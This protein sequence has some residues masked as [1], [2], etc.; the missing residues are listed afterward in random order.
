MIFKTSSNFKFLGWNL[1]SIN[2]IKTEGGYW[3]WEV[4]K[5]TVSY[6]SDVIPVPVCGKL[7]SVGLITF[8]NFTWMLYLSS[9]KTFIISIIHC[10]FIHEMN[11]KL[12]VMESVTKS[13]EQSLAWGTY[14]RWARID[15]SCCLMPFNSKFCM[16]PSPLMHA[17]RYAHLM[18]IQFMIWLMFIFV[19]Q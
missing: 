4:T 11:W 9:S 10:A 2:G 8:T 13:M 17:I 1:T 19:L 15:S 5:M 6:C 14:N 18:S 12:E 3:E 16:V 7:S